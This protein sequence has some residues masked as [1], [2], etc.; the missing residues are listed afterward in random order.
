MTW[1]DKLNRSKRSS[2]INDRRL[3]R[4]EISMTSV[5]SNATRTLVVW[6]VIA[7]LS[8]LAAM[9]TW[10]WTVA[11]ADSATHTLLMQ[12]QLA[13]WLSAAQ[14]LENGERGYLLTKDESYLDHYRSAKELIDKIHTNLKELVSGNS[15]QL[16]MVES[17][18]VTLRQ[19]LAAIEKVIADF[20]SGNSSASAQAAEST[21]GLTLMDKLREQIAAAK[22]QEE[23]LFNQHVD[24]F[25]RQSF[26]LLGAVLATLIASAALAMVALIRERQRTA[27]LEISALTLASTNRMLEDRVKER[28]EELAVERDH[29]KVERERAEAL[30]RDV[31]HRIGNTL[32]LVA[33]FINLH[34]RH[35]SDPVAVKILTGARE[36][37][38]A[39]ASAQRRISVTNDL[40]LVRI[41]TLIPAVMADLVSAAS[42][43]RIKLS[44][45]VPPLLAAAQVATSLCVLAQEFV[46]NSLKHAFGDYDTGE[47]RVSLKQH[48]P[49]GADLVVEDDGLGMPKAVKTEGQEKAL[50]GEGLGTKIAALLTRQFAGEISYEPARASASRPGTRVI[51]RLTDLDLR[52]VTEDGNDPVEALSLGLIQ[53]K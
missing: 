53:S 11:T 40:D 4:I 17:I 34:V 30:L 6:V 9:L 36:R 23:R 47:I 1:Y 7:T 49:K 18:G 50:E 35:T 33:G 14:D 13:G 32:A 41:D 2:F 21:L 15:E 25:Q 46:V 12:Q 31:T 51:V 24:Q 44:V 22:D 29:A 28:T 45:N 3:G 16:A 26:W 20:S 48:G 19:R 37:V 52:P 38:Q 27:A 5:S 42:E 10:R 43:D 39:I 8:G